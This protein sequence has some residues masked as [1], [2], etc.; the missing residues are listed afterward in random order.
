MLGEVVN[1]LLLIFSLYGH[2]QQKVGKIQKIFSYVFPKY[3]LSSRGESI[4]Q[5]NFNYNFLSFTALLKICVLF[6][7][8]K[9]LLSKLVFLKY[10]SCTYL[11]FTQ[12]AVLSSTFKRPLLTCKSMIFPCLMMHLLICQKLLNIKTIIISPFD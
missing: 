8:S 6:L 7:Y 3:L 12:T 11:Q 4:N 2:P 1:F 10:L 5:Y 9:I